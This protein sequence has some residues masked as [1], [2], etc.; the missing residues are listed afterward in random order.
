LWYLAYLLAH[1]LLYFAVL[2]R[3]TQFRLERTIFLYHATSAVC[4]SLI[5]LATW[6][7]PGSGVDLEWVVAVIAMHGIYSIS[8]LELWSLADGGY[9]LQI[10]EHVQRA[11]RHGDRPDDEALRAIG[12]AKQGDRLTGLIGAGLVRQDA[13]RLSLT[14]SGRAVASVF[15][16][17]AWLTHTQDGV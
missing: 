7:V 17:L 16:L 11:E 2:R 5:V 4:V 15:A 9:S 1:L 14:V 8:F 6:F 3:F 10:L 12:I 13:D